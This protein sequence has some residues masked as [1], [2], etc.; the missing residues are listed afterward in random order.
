[1]WKN[2]AENYGLVSKLLHWL[3]AISVFAMF[4]VGFWMV[5]LTYYS[6]WYQKA[7]HWHESVGILLLSATLLRLFWRLFS[8]KPQ[9]IINHSKIERRASS[10]THL[11]L[12]VLIF[13]LFIS[14]YLI[15][16]ADGR[17]IDI[18]NWFSVAG[19]E[20]LI[21]NQEDL[22]G[23]VHEYVAYILITTALLHGVA[24]V[25]HHVIDKDRTLARMIKSNK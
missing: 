25:K 4:G 15:S 7:P 13:T 2:T 14:G 20:K 3:S 22:A 11:V 24:A 10:T 6:P 12:Y 17:A 9:A 8:V 16:T 5:D 23:L 1:M 18:F 19:L 21:E